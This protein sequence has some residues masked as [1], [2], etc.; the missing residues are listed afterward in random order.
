MMNIINLEEDNLFSIV[1]P[2]GI[3]FISEWTDFGIFPYPHIINKQIPGCGFTEYCIRNGQ[4]LVLC[5]P[6][7]LLLENKTDQHPGE[8]FYVMSPNDDAAIDKETAIKKSS[9]GVAD[10]KPKKKKKELSKAEKGELYKKLVKDVGAYILKR[11]NEGKPFKI[12]VTYDSFYIVKNILTYWGQLGTTQIVIDEWQ[13]IFIDSAFKGDT[14]NKFLQALV[15]LE[16][17]CFVSATPM[18]EGYMREVELFDKMPFY[19]LDWSTDDPVRVMKPALRVRKTID[20]ST[21]VAQEVVRSYLSGNFEKKLVRDK[22][23]GERRWV[24][25][26]EAVLYLNSVNSILTVIRR[27]KLKPEQ[28][29]I[30]CA[31][32]EENKR[33]ISEKLDFTDEHGIRYRFSLGSIPLEGQQHKMFTFCTRTV[34]LGAD[35]YSTCAR[36]FVFSDANVETLTVDISLDLPQ[37]LGRQRLPENPWKNEAE[38]FYKPYY[39]KLTGEKLSPAEYKAIIDRKVK[40]TENL[41]KAY[42]DSEDEIKVSLA[43]VYESNAKLFYKDNYISVKQEFID[44]ETVKKT[45]EFN[46]LV[47]IAERRAFDLQQTDYADRF[48]VFSSLVG[49]GFSTT[50]DQGKVVEFFAEFKKLD[51]L[52]KKLKYFM[53]FSCDQNTKTVIYNQITEKHF[54]E[55]V[56]AFTEDEIKRCGYSMT[57]LKS[58]LGIIDFNEDALNKAIHQEFKVGVAMSNTDIKDKLTMLY[59][60][61]GYGAKPKAN[62]LVRWFDLKKIK[63]KDPSGKWIHGLEL[64]KKTV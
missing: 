38:F 27:M 3:R 59:Q 1:V 16:K 14:E 63:I 26:K 57:K 24:E 51:S 52:S 12:L 25:S 7:K 45:P 44:S 20:A 36:T 54:H 13:S 10:G 2:R 55:C 15:G 48:S 53:N 40:D 39:S 6:R 60:K 61:L 8:V 21:T 5:S 47:W 46:K 32:T 19:I 42:A 64:M 56:D 30:L 4:D 37:I 11:H 22:D 35:F 17:L 49:S 58:M 23:T 62:D 33:K 28:V 41:L 31:K 29:N 34:Y 43:H 18:I 9:K 50:C